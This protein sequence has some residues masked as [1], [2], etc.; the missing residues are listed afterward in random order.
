MESE[1][2]EQRTDVLVEHHVKW[3]HQEEQEDVRQQRNTKRLTKIIILVAVEQVEQ[4]AENHTSD[5]RR[6]KGND[7]QYER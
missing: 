6:D 3:D 7:N 5:E 4:S 2:V 1:N